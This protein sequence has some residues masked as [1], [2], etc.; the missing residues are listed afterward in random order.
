ME[1]KQS[2]EWSEARAFV[3]GE[4]EDVLVSRPGVVFPPGFYWTHN[5]HATR[6]LGKWV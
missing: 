4:C 6:V 5:A 2:Q 1:R 3:L